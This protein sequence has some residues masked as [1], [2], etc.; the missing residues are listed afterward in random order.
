MAKNKQAENQPPQR[1]ELSEAKIA[2][3]PQ[4]SAQAPAP[5]TMEAIV[6]LAKRRGFIWQGSEIYA[7][8]GCLVAIFRGTAR[9][10]VRH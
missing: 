7:H 10:H 5:S 3:A 9:R 1:T 8:H 2:S 4:K 6:A